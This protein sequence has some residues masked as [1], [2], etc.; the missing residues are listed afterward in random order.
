MWGGW[1][2]KPLLVQFLGFAHSQTIGVLRETHKRATRAAAASCDGRFL[3]RASLSC[4]K[5]TPTDALQC[6][7]HR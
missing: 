2:C 4:G 3:L 7:R 5:L 1:P 6:N